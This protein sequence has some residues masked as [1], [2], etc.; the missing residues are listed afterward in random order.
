MCG[1][2]TL[3]L[4]RLRQAACPQRLAQ[5]RMSV[6]VLTARRPFCHVLWILPVAVGCDASLSTCMQPQLLAEAPSRLMRLQLHTNPHPRTTLHS[7]CWLSAPALPRCFATVLP[8]P[9]EVQGTC[10]TMGF[11]RRATEHSAGYP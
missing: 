9:L 8:K 10:R 6:G 7:L 2:S 3:L 11:L 4:Q 1:C 5:A